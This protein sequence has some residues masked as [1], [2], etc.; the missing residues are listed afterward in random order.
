MTIFGMKQEILITKNT[1]ITAFTLSS[2]CPKTFENMLTF[3]ILF[4]LARFDKRK[5]FTEE[6]ILF[7]IFF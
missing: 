2:R 5:L 4:C 6:N 3:P 7:G 1:L